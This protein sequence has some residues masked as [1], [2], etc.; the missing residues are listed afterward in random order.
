MSPQI[1]S[2]GLELTAA[3]VDSVVVKDIPADQASVP[4]TQF[5]AVG[6]SVS[7][8][9]TALRKR[10][11]HPSTRDW[12]L[13]SGMHAHGKL[14]Y[15]RRTGAFH[16]DAPGEVVHAVAS[17]VS[18]SPGAADTPTEQAT[19]WVDPSINAARAAAVERMSEAVATA[20]R[21]RNETSVLLREDDDA[22]KLEILLTET[23]ES[24]AVAV[25]DEENIAVK[26]ASIEEHDAKA[27][28]ACKEIAAK[29][30]AVEAELAEVSRMV[31][32]ETAALE[33]G[34]STYRSARRLAFEKLQHLEACAEG[35][36][37]AARRH[38]K[39]LRALELLRTA[40][41][42]EHKTLEGIAEKS[43][44]LQEYYRQLIGTHAC[45]C[46]MGRESMGVGRGSGCVRT[47]RP[48]ARAPRC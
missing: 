23:K 39:Q 1:V 27:E 21:L 33:E 25:K 20:E 22:E 30:A 19:S 8:H 36:R 16:R 48:G 14:W 24:L 28:V 3:E 10:V 31:E 38:Q 35:E 32:H 40:R 7:E 26:L 47:W 41:H 12:V 37:I 46:S 5:A 11:M 34:T 15:N 42:A 4:L 29:Q 45:T 9:V 2:S 18:T 17:A 44:R 13:V 43:T 6:A